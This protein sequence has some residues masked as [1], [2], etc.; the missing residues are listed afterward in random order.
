[1]V[2]IFGFRK[3]NAISF[4]NLGQNHRKDSATP[5]PSIRS[6][7]HVPEKSGIT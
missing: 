1:M 6:S 4:N 5:Y 7:K 3:D 2:Y